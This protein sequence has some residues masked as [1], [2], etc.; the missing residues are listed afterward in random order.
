MW[1]NLILTTFQLAIALKALN[2]VGLIHTD[3]K[4]DN[5]MLVNQKKYPFKVKLIDFGL[6]TDMSSL[7]QNSLVQP[8][9]Y[10]WFIKWE[11]KIQ[12]RLRMEW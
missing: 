4:M 10:R 3:I 2:G 7:R 5:I 11:F 9:G 12:R 6:A 1:L 8:L